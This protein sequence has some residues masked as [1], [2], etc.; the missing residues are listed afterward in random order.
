[1]RRSGFDSCGGAAL[2]SPTAAAAAALPLPLCFAARAFPDLLLARSLLLLL[3][4]LL[5]P[6]LLLPPNCWLLAPCDPHLLLF[7]SWRLPVMMGN[8]RGARVAFP[9]LLF[10]GCCLVSQC[11]RIVL[12][13]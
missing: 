8:G 12:C 5:P 13:R 7:L 4:L 2:F 6:S 1:M 3:P 10:R 11:L 9:S